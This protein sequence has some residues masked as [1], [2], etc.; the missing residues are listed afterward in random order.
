MTRR[1]SSPWQIE[2]DRR[3]P[4]AMDMVAP[5]YGDGRYATVAWCGGLTVHLHATRDAAERS[6][7]MIDETGCG[8]DCWG[9]HELV[10]LAEP[11]PIDPARERDRGHQ[12]ALHMQT[13]H[14]CTYVYSGKAPAAALARARDR[15]ARPVGDAA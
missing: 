13:C 1:R 12:R 8:H 4:D 6:L 11:E 15:Q 3:W 14:V 5:A 10:D 7:A 2:A 9:D